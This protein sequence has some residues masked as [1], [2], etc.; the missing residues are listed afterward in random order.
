MA[1]A[2]VIPVGWKF[3]VVISC[4][5]HLLLSIITQCSTFNPAP[6]GLSSDPI[7]DAQFSDPVAS[8]DFWPWFLSSRLASHDSEVDCEDICDSGE[9]D[10]EGFFSGNEGTPPPKP[11]E[12]DRLAN[13]DSQFLTWVVDG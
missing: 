2:L 1:I 5:Q 10:L 6:D 3:S 8:A 7:D 12:E 13:E 4:D 9:V 11:Y